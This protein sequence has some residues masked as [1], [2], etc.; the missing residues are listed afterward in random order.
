MI[1]YTKYFIW[2]QI[3]IPNKFG[4]WSKLEIRA[5][6]MDMDVLRQL[7]G[8]RTNWISHNNLEFQWI[9]WYLGLSSKFQFN[10]TCFKV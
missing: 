7:E 9:P 6:S 1:M 8:I 2:L 4:K 5:T 3:D 10:Q